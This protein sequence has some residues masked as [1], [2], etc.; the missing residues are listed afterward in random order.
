MDSQEERNYLLIFLEHFVINVFC[1]NNS[2]LQ[3]KWGQSDRNLA[4]W[5]SKS[6]VSVHI[7]VNAQETLFSGDKSSEDVFI[8]LKM[9]QKHCQQSL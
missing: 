3:E 9:K 2:S 5:M 1:K 6:M 4:I 8:L 7:H